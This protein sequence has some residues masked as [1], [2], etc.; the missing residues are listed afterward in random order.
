MG[1]YALSGILSS[2]GGGNVPWGV[3]GSFWAVLGKFEGCFRVGL[4]GFLCP[5]RNSE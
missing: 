3:L 5:V 1:F 4:G 2:L